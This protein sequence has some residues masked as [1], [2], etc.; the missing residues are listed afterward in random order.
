MATNKFYIQPELALEQCQQQTELGMT[1]SSFSPFLVSHF[2]AVE[3]SDLRAP[4][5]NKR[6]IVKSETVCHGNNK[7]N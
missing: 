6:T 7:M 5:N 1:E 2:T 4:V 3:N